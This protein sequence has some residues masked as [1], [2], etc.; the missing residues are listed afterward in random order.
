MS[1]R[2][3]FL[4]AAVAVSGAAAARAPLGVL[5]NGLF[6]GAP[7]PAL[8]AFPAAE[9]P[10]DAVGRRSLAED[11]LTFFVKQK[12]LFPGRSVYLLPAAP[13]FGG[14]EPA[15]SLMAWDLT[16]SAGQPLYLLAAADPDGA[17]DPAA[18]SITINGAPLR[19]LHDYVHGGITALHSGEPKSHQV[20][21]LVFAPPAPGRYKIEVENGDST[22]LYDLSVR[23][24]DALGAALF[25]GPHGHVY[26][27]QGRARRLVPD[28]ETLH[29]LGYPGDAVVNATE[30]AIE[31]LPEAAPL[32]PLRDGQLVRSADHPAVFKLQAGRRIWLRDF[33]AP[34]ADDSGDALVQTIDAAVLAAIP[35]VLQHD[36]LLKSDGLDVF[37]VDGASLRKVPDWKWA[38]ERKLDPSDT[39]YVPERILLGLAQNSPHWVAP[40]GSFEDHDFESDA[41]DR[42][43]PYRVFL[44]PDYH[45]TH[46][47]G[48]RYPV[49]YLLHGMGGRYDEWSGYGVEEVA[50]LLFDE[51][52]LGHAIIVAPQGGLGYWMNQDGGTPWGEYVARDLVRHVDATYRTIVRR[53]AR[54]VGG[55]SMGGHGALQ[56][57]LN[58]PDVFGVAGAHSASI[59]P[60]SQA[61][62]YFGRGSGFARRDPLTLALDAQL[63]APPRIWM[64]AG[65]DDH[66]RFPIHELHEILEKKEW[67]HE[68]H[69]WE[70]GHDGWYW[71]DHIWDYLPFYSRAFEKNGIPLVR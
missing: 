36:M 62:R 41:L 56:L 31:T 9:A 49:I 22:L 60:E 48:Q 64:D 59:R 55:L 28:A 10:F 33:T 67:E 16:V 50:N 15:S 70:G 19:N 24:A 18:T 51:R 37:H 1:N 7:G 52:K 12:G 66:W 42:R 11:L 8:V 47:A 26:A 13:W 57:A 32:P 23:A 14:W 46:R 30:D 3:S 21:D 35:P 44:P 38:A 53:E 17:L 63:N 25:R 34:T 29:A 65:D 6:Q 43:L 20:L 39:F 54:A 58:Y 40:G 68:Y 27:T 4:T 2:R 5:A 69:V 61:P 45:A 71:G